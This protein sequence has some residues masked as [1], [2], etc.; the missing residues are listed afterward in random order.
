MKPSRQPA[1]GTVA[2]AS[3]VLFWRSAAI[4]V[5]RGGEESD[6]GGESVHAVDE[7]DGVG[8]GHQP[9]DGDR[10]VPPGMVATGRAVRAIPGQTL[11]VNTRPIGRARRGD[12]SGELLPRLQAPDVIDQSDDEDEAGGR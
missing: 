1:S 3:A 12:L 10:K 5:V 4:S 9:E 2:S 11:D 7:I 6:A 8:A